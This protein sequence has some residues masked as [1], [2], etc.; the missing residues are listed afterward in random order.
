M[1]ITKLLVAATMTVNAAVAFAQAPADLQKVKVL[2][3]RSMPN[4]RTI[5]LA[6]VRLKSTSPAP[7][8]PIV[9]LD[10]G[11]GGSGIGLYRVDEFKRLFDTLRE[12]GDVIL[13]S[14]RG[15]GFSTPRLTCSGDGPVPD[16]LFASAQHMTTVLGPR[17]VACANEQRAKGIDLSSYN[18]EASADDLEDLRLALGVPKITL[19]GFSYG[20]HL[21]L[22]AVRRHPTS[23]DKVILAGTEGP[24]DSQ[25]YPHTFDLQ[26]AR[27]SFLEAKLAKAPVPNLI[28]VTRSVLANLE[29][30]PVHAGK[31]TIGK[32]GLQYLLRRDIGDTNDT[33]TVIRMIRDT[34]KGDYAL[35]AKFAERRAGGFSGG[36]SMMGYAM[37]CASGISPERLTRIDRELPHGLLGTMTNYPFPEICD[38]LQVVP[39]PESYRSPIVSTLPTLFIS[40][41]L[42]SNTPPY[43]A[44]Q[45]RW[46]FPNSVH[47]IVE[48]AGHESTLQLADVQKAMVDFLKGEDVAGR[49]IVAPSPLQQ[50]VVSAF[51]SSLRHSSCGREPADRR[52]RAWC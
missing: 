29:K 26:L 35:L 6:Y 18:T 9:Y 28:E 2:E 30:A 12:V 11:P 8:T 1:S 13:V 24:D 23:I 42:D 49:R 15:T 34:A 44:E 38:A 22:A 25:K 36:P 41:S 46:G 47:L 39:L 21:G 7:G 16:D 3:D 52:S 10:G 19:F 27:L 4:G 32:E 40:G 20:T 50:A 17:L 31:F 14:Q 37:D 45:V 33:A 5:E 43:Q 51:R 48:N